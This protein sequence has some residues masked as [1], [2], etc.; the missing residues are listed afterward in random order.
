M[1]LEIMAMMVT[2]YAQILRHTHR[3]GM[4]VIDMM[5]HF[6][7]HTVTSRE[8]E[9]VRCANKALVEGPA[10]AGLVSSGCKGQHW[11]GEVD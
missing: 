1:L 10:P 3:L 8:G 4:R 7:A 5:T 9:C 6:L 2:A 11:H